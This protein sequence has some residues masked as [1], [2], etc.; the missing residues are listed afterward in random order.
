M[1]KTFIWVERLSFFLVLSLL[2]KSIL[3]G[4]A[5]CYSEHTT[6][7]MGKRLL[8]LLEKCH[9]LNNFRRI[10]ISLEKRKPYDCTPYY[11]FIENLNICFGQFCDT[12]LSDKPASFKNMVKN[13]LSRSVLYKRFCFITAVETEIAL[14]GEMK[15]NK[16]ILYI[17]HHPLNHTIVSFLTQRGFIIKESLDYKETVKLFIGPC[18]YIAAVLL[19][20]IIP[21]KIKS[22]ISEV[23]PSIWVEYLSHDY[24]FDLTFWKQYVNMRDFDMVYY[25]DRS[26]TPIKNV[27]VKE[28]E[29]L[30]YK[31][32]DAHSFSLMQMSKISLFNV[33]RYIHEIFNKSLSLPLWFR[34]FNFYYNFWLCTYTSIFKYYKVK[35][36]IQHQDH[37]WR[38]EVQKK[39][40]ESSGG[41]IIGFH[42]SNYLTSYEPVIYFPYQVYF[43]WGKTIYDFVQKKDNTCKYIIPS[44]LWITDDKK[45][46]EGLNNLSYNLNF[47]IN[48]FDSS[49]AYYLHQTPDTLSQFYLRIL[50]LIEDNPSWGVIVKSKNCENLYEFSE[51][52]QGNEII[53]RMHNLIQQ[54]RLVI[55]SD[56]TSPVSVLS[57]ANLSICYGV[58]TAGIIAGIHGYKAIHWDCSGWLKHPFYKDSEQKFIFKTLDELEEAIIKVANGD[59]TIGDFS[60]WRQKLNYFDDF[61]AP[62]RVGKFIQTFMNEIIKTDNMKH[63]LD[64]AVNRY[65]EENKIGED[66][67][68]PD[69]WWDEE[70]GK[71]PIKDVEQ[72]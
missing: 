22:N 8:A 44:G 33:M 34:V 3:Y 37:F 60:K 12:Y 15:K 65:I 10:N 20:K 5:I 42:W 48:I 9:L 68:K 2:I 53:L 45:K 40:I 32:I 11:R 50:Q 24:F 6:S 59:K 62:E 63:S 1:T 52:P 31:W 29:K 61:K 49:T 66:L 70:Q 57:Y 58:N 43:L 38:Q 19:S 39:A 56:A 23:R 18:Y 67:F 55:L 16:H 21:A 26:D 30:G 69:D 25:I 36:L 14:K 64:F 27:P 4:Y 47:I 54:G 13:Y 72:F 51:L 46:I 7:P 41:I 28:I 35:L 71:E 17:V